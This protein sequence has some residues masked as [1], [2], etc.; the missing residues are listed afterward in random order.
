MRSAPVLLILL[1]DFSE[2]DRLGRLWHQALADR[3]ASSRTAIVEE[4][5]ASRVGCIGRSSIASLAPP[6]RPEVVPST[7]GEDSS[8]PTYCPSR[9][10]NWTSGVGA[11]TD[12][13][14]TTFSSSSDFV[15][16]RLM[17]PAK[18]PPGPLIAS[19]L[20]DNAVT[21][22]GIFSGISWAGIG[23]Q[24]SVPASAGGESGANVWA[25]TPAPAMLRTAAKAS[26]TITP[27]PMLRTCLT[28]NW[29]PQYE[30]T[31]APPLGVH[32][33]DADRS[34]GHLLWPSQPAR[35]AMHRAPARLQP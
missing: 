12:Q 30:A 8:A 31:T 14:R 21:S 4:L 10:S 24:I 3:S 35:S 5:V 32:H 13:T 2:G 20:H 22:S 17:V 16:A 19:K 6:R 25:R 23:V 29:A 1:Q 34:A 9:S 28:A 18:T 15:P 11:N 33:W 27:E 26:L 7:F